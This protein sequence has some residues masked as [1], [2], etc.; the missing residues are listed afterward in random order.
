[1]SSATKKPPLWILVVAGLTTFVI[2]AAVVWALPVWLW[3]FV[4]GLGFGVI[5]ERRWS[6]RRG[7]S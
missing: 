6:Q 2:L 4:A 3:T 5:G 7:G 1:M